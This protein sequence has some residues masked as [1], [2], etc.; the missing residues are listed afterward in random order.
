MQQEIGKKLKS[1]RKKSG[2]SLAS[3][4]ELSGVSTGLLSQIERGMV[5]PSVVTLSHIANALKVDIAYFFS[6]QTTAYSLQRKGTQPI[7][8]TNNGLDKHIMLNGDWDN[9]PLDFLHLTLKGGEKYETE[10]ISHRGEEFAYVIKGTL[11]FIIDGE[12]LQLNEGDS[13]S[14]SSTHPHLYFNE[15]EEDCESIWA[16]T[17]KFF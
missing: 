5:A 11:S 17:P 1:L 10:T 7:I 15:G 12:H 6:S 14:F 2:L 9:R 4:S 3:L 13:I 16:I 8:T